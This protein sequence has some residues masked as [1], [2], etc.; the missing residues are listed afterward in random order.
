MG[1]DPTAVARTPPTGRVRFKN[2]VARYDSEGVRVIANDIPSSEQYREIRAG[3][4]I[5][6][7]AV[8]PRST[9][10][11]TMDS[12]TVIGTNEGPSILIFDAKG[13]MNEIGW[14]Q[15]PA[16]VKSEHISLFIDKILNGTVQGQELLRDMLERSTTPDLL[17]WYDDIRISE[18]NQIWVRAHSLQEQE[19]AYW[20]IF[21][22][23]GELVS[24][25]NLPV[26]FEPHIISSTEILGVWHDELGVQTLALFGR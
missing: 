16:P 24:W 8:L 7:P 17:P 2:V 13:N 15:Q 4:V 6:I 9:I 26:D 10:I 14:R 20:R 25:I 5:S 21:D 3:R 22:L 23:S 19:A 12:L 18:E 11:R 1:D